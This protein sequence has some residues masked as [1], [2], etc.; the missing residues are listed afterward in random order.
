MRTEEWKVRDSVWGDIFLTSTDKKILDTFE[1]QRLRGIKQLD[2]AFL[3]YPGAE[4]SRFQHSLGVRACVDKIISMS[5]IP[6]DDE[7]VRFVRL[8]A[9]LH[10]VATPVFSHVVSDFFRRF[11][12]NIIPPHEKF[13]SEIVE[14][15]CYKKFQKENPE[16][17]DAA[18]PLREV[19]E[20]EG[21]G[22]RD[23]SRI[24]EII[25][26]EGKP[27]YLSQLVNGPLDA[28]RLDYLKRD[29]YYTGVPQSYDDRIFSSFEIDGDGRLALKNRTDAIGAA[30][31]VLESRFWMMKK[32]YLH[33]TTLAASC[34]AL[35]LLLKGLGDYDF[36]HLF[37]LDDNQ[38]INML[39]N[40]SVEEA[41]KLAYRLR[42]R[43]IPKKAYAAHIS[44]FPEKV[45]RAALGM[46]DYH[47]LRNEIIME[48]RKLQHDVDISEI[49]VFIYLPRDYY[50][51][52]SEVRAGGRGL[53]EY[54]PNLVQTLK[55]RY[56]SL[57]QVY[58]FAEKRYVEDVK[59]VC[60]KIFRKNRGEKG[61]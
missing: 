22:K 11:Y 29:A 38:F 44:E 7:E 4:H 26:G 51:E 14:G 32:V 31:S 46:V 23:R 47:E 43:R 42:Y 17:M 21:Y 1:L 18:I 61:E 10:D 30:I 45:S 56:N 58:V 3:V 24:V 25:M 37:F 48:V 16:I 52:V 13:V 41:R 27:R 8:A 54:D 5:K 20:E 6:L 28:D 49:D 2:F 15:V 50:T 34:L 60:E 36:Y 35:E 59:K 19:L 55:A 40:S 9:L 39:A 33:H 12:P 53:E 57:M